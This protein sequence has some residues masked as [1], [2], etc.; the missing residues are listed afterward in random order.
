MSGDTITERKVIS[1]KLDEFSNCW[2]RRL[3]AR[4]PLYPFLYG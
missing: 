4:L 3:V 1:R 2:N